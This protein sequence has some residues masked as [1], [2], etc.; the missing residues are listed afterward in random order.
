[1]SQLRKDGQQVD[2]TLEWILGYEPKFGL[3][4]TD[5]KTLQRTPKLSAQ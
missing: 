1:M 2:K 3:F 4:R 5:M